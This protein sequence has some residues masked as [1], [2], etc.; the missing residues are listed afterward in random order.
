M[1]SHDFHVK[2]ND[3]PAFWHEAVAESAKAFTNVPYG[4][5]ADEAEDGIY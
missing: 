1:L 3:G 5:H 4:L 2:V